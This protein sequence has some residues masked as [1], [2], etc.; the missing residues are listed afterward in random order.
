[1]T[2]RTLSKAL[3]VGLLS[4]TWLLFPGGGVAAGYDRVVV[5]GDSLTDPG[6]AFV[7]LRSVAVRPGATVP[8]LKLVSVPPFEFIPSAPYARGG[9]HFS[10]GATWVEQLAEALGVGRSAGPAW[11][12]PGVFSNYAVGGA[13]ARPGGPSE[14]PDLTSQVS[15]FLADVGGVAPADALYVIHIG[16]DD[17]RDGLLA[18]ATDP[19]AV[20]SLTIVAEALAAIRGNL[21]TLFS[22]GA[23]AFL[24]PNGPDL[25]LVPAVRLA[26]AQAGGQFLAAIFNTGLEIPPIAGLANI[27]DDL[28]AIQGVTVFRVDAFALLDDVVATPADFGLSEV[29]TPCLIFTETLTSIPPF[30]CAQPDEF[31][32]W[33]GIHPTRAGHA[34]LARKALEVL[35]AP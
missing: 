25:A 24:V 28:A 13:R 6:N 19:S 12:K 8:P 27:L 2:S 5:F 22:A 15:R 31:L 32:F 14:S 34:I 11:R 16:G 10:N 21:M 18:F 4:L 29:S 30:F 1:M 17:L 7:L 35:T 23:R 26:G 20:T 3:A 33:D 9:L